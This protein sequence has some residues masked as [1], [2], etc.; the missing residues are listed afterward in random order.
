MTQFVEHEL[1]HELAEKS[2]WIH[3]CLP[4]QEDD[5]ENLPDD[6]KFPTMDQIADDLSSL[7]D[8]HHIPSV[9]GFG[10]GAGADILYRFGLKYPS[11]CSGLVLINCNNKDA[12]KEAPFLRMKLFSTGSDSSDLNMNNVL[13]YWKS[14][15]ERTDLKHLIKENRMVSVLLA[16]GQQ[17]EHLEAVREMSSHNLV[18]QLMVTLDGINPLSDSPMELARALILFCKGCGVLLSIPMVGLENQFRT[19]KEHKPPTSVQ[20]QIAKKIMQFENMV[21]DEGRL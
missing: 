13:L 17:S 14:Y 18:S 6:F 2:V 20:L 9:F 19:V 11:K 16:A 3:V 8:Q 7:M 5:A 4:G 1:M 12:R 10:Y 15:S 21:E